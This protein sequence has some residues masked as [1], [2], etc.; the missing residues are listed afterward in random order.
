M[1]VRVPAPSLAA[2]VRAAAAA[3]VSVN[4]ADALRA[5]AEAA[6]A[7]AEAEIAVVRALDG[8]GDRLEAVAVAAPQT[9]AAELEG[10]VL[11]AAELPGETLD[12]LASAPPAVRR[13]AERTGATCL[14]LVPARAD[15]CA[16]SLELLRSGGPFGVEQRLAAE[17]CAAQAILVIRA[18][19]TAG[20]GSPLARP[21]LELAGEA[22]AAALHEQDAAAEV[23]RLAAGVAGA[24]AAILWEVREGGLVSAASWGVDTY[25]DLSA[26]RAVAVGT[27][28]EPGPVR[29]QA[30]QRLPTDEVSTTLPLGSPP[31]GV[32]QLL[33]PAG[34]EPDAAQLAGLATF[35]VRA[36]H[37]LR[38][39]KRAHLLALE[40]ERTR[41]LLE[42]KIGR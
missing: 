35:G 31:L 32:L 7:V 22:L 18:F 37:A 21:A 11:P 33:H 25:D 9:L 1:D 8:S 3:A 20:D 5:L 36:G 23:V 16:V 29:A 2:L 12:A 30:A 40:L 13:I 34:D 24:S 6:R 4:P 27:L 15:G 38:A 14:L 10:T 39:G 19:A 28:A 26:A 42:V 41:A 17:L